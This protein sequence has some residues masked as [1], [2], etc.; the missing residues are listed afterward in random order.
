[1]ARTQDSRMWV[2]R[3]RT[4]S[5]I[6][7]WVLFLSIISLTWGKEEGSEITLEFWDC[8][9]VHGGES[10]WMDL[11]GVVFLDRLSLVLSGCRY[12]YVNTCW[13]TRKAR[14]VPPVGAHIT[15]LDAHTPVNP[16]VCMYFWYHP[17]YGHV[18]CG[19]STLTWR[20]SV[21]MSVIVYQAKLPVRL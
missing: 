9:L 16:S 7:F 14:F 21:H 1:M 3:A 4:R 15:H 5:G 13:V 18:Y 19:L 11:L 6:R 17:T 2:S 10:G 12:A 8:A 20:W